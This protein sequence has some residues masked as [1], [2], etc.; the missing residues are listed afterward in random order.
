MYAKKCKKEPVRGEVDNYCTVAIYCTTEISGV[1]E[2][3]IKSSG[4][5]GDAGLE[6]SIPLSCGPSFRTRWIPDV[7]CLM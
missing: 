2:T 7:N 4:K 3:G 1:P 6:G 5:S